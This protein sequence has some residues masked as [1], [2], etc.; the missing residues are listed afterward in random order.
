MDVFVLD[1]GILK[2]NFQ[3]IFKLDYWIECCKEFARCDGP[4]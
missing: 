1:K 2:G 3:S 4:L